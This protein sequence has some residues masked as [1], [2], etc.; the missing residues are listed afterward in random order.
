MKDPSEQLLS[1][2]FLLQNSENLFTSMTVSK[3][4]LPVRALHYNS[5]CFPKAQSFYNHLLFVLLASLEIAYNVMAVDKQKKPIIRN[6][7]EAR[8]M[9]VVI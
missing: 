6:P 4:I 7:I 2:K 9:F 5:S 3:G 1:C 8:A